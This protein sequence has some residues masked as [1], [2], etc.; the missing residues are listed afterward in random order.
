[1]AMKKELEKNYDPSVV[2]DRLYADWQEKDYFRADIDHNKKRFSIMIPPPNI[3]SNLHLGHSFEQTL[4]DAVTR[5]KRMQGYSALW[6]PGTDHASISTEVK[7]VA[8]MAKE[9]VSKADIGREGFLTRAWDWKEKYGGI[10]VSQIKKLGSSCDWSREA[11]TMDGRLT[12]ATKTVFAELYKQGYIYRGKKLINWCVK[13]KTTVSDAEVDHI[14]HHGYYY[15]MSYRIDGE[16]DVLSFVTSRPETILGDT[17]IAVNPKDTRYAHL[18]GKTVT[19]PIVNRKI[20]IIADEYVDMEFGTGVVKIT[21]AHDPNDF[22]VGVRHNLPQINVLNDDGTINEN[23]GS[24]EGLDRYAAREKIVGEF[25]RLG[26]FIKLEEMDN[27]VGEHERCHT[28]IEPILKTQW[29]VKMEELAKPAAE[30]VKSGKL[31]FHPERHA[32]VY[33]NWL[34]NI[35]DWCISRQLWWGHRIPA[36]YCADCGHIT[37]SADDVHA[38]EKCGGVVAQDEDCLDTWFS[39]AL[40]PFATLGWPDK[41]EELD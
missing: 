37:V 34:E 11:F 30:A 39:S 4:Q 27:A 8:A 19:V 9:G 24:Y 16:D 31:R 14:E 32:K 7:I 28:V 26:L 23:G 2:E 15:H 1:M 3:T 10:I 12:K 6:L 40:W 22:E 17:A 5:W 18:V 36:F 21:P 25:K 13:C 20:P 41:T 35:R 33:L 38:C 29:F